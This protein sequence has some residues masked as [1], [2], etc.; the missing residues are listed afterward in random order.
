MILGKGSEIR[1][2][3]FGASYNLSK[4]IKKSLH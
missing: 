1:A 2:K 3:A 4:I